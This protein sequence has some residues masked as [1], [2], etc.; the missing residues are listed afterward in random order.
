MTP[1]YEYLKLWLTP[2]RLARFWRRVEKRADGCWIWTG[3][4]TDSEHGRYDVDGD[5]QRVH[6]LTW[7]LA[8]ERDIPETIMWKG[9]QKPTVIRHLLCDNKPCCN[10]AHSV[11]G[12]QGENVADIWLLH[13]P[14]DAAMEW[15]TIEA[16][17]LT[18]YVGYFHGASA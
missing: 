17:K 3:A 12:A 8:R 5:M 10:P 6:R 18:P 11:A 1:T 7:I 2:T 13:K 15:E 16:Y 14:Y 4:I 9:E